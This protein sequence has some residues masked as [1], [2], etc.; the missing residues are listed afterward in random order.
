MGLVT[1]TVTVQLRG[2]GMVAPL[3]PTLGLPL[4]ATTVPPA[5]VVAPLAGLALTRFAGY[6]SVKAAPVI[7]TA[8]E[9]VSVMVRVEVAFTP[10]ADGLNALRSAERRVGKEGRAPWSPYH[11]KIDGTLPRELR[12]WAAA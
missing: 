4:M 2:G 11:S 9:L 1:S 8:F 10:T 3:A 6:V 5:H 7:A 12:Y